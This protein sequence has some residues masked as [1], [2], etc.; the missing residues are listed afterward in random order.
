MDDIVEFGKSIGHS[1][2]AALNK[3]EQQNAILKQQVAAL[4]KLPKE[5][6]D[7]KS[8]LRKAKA[9][10]AEKEEMINFLKKLRAAFKV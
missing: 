2:E 9:L 3:S 10:I 5:V 6:D 8:E 7:L 4:E 1:L